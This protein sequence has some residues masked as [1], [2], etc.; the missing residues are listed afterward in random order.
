[1]TA[2]MVALTMTRSMAALGDDTL[3]GGDGADFLNDTSGE[4]LLFGGAG[5]DTING[6]GSID[7]GLGNDQISYNWNNGDGNDTVSGGA[8]NDT[9]T[10][11]G[12]IPPGTPV[13]IILDGGG[14]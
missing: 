2:L 3:D 8:G 10:V 6:S 9:I 5:N 4:N 14:R 12:S 1:M 13:N 11:N 7:G